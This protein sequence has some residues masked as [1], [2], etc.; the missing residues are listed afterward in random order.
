MASR[1][2]VISDNSDNS[3]IADFIVTLF[4]FENVQS[5]VS[6]SECSDGTT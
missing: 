4:D 3:V 2:T 1:P 6:N 5:E